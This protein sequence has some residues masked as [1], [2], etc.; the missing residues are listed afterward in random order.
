MRLAMAGIALS[1]IGIAAP[2]SAQD[3]KDGFAL[4]GTTR[5]RYEA[6]DG[7]ARAGFNAADD[8]VNLRTTVLGQY[9]DGPIRIAAELW[10]SRVYAG[11][12][13]TPI[14]TGE[15]NTLE[16]A[17]A[18]AEVRPHAL[19]GAGSTASLQAGRFLLNLGS[20]RLVAA[21][22]YRNTT[23][24]Y[25]G[26][27]AELAWRGGW[28]AILI[29]TLPQQRRPDDPAELR[30]NAVAVD[31]EGVDL[32]LWG[33]TISRARAIRRTM[34]ETSFF[35][36]GE[37]D[38]PQRPTRDRL[39]NTLGLRLISDPAPGKLDGELE[40]FVQHGHI[41]TGL[42]ANAARQDVGA[43][44]VH[45]DAGY[46]WAGDWHPRLSIEFDHASGDRPGGRYGRFDTLLGMRRADLGPSGLYNAFG[47]ANFISPGARI[48]A[49]PSKRTDVMAT[50][51]PIWLAA[52]EDS[53]STT[54]VR[55]AS[56]RSGTFA[57]T[58]V[59][60]RL[61]HRLSPALRLELDAVVLCK[62]RFLRDALNAPPGR[63]T[64]Y[65]SL[66]FTVVL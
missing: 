28:R 11:D 13:G 60:G 50:L 62:G 48:E 58:Q 63:W 41:S 51:R 49:A 25:T 30:H 19:L 65:A 43:W 39:L 54:G 47:R 17:Q 42:S 2:A 34:I 53:F 14:T 31:H 5:L 9:R 44:F 4:S 52:R 18:F 61:R 37:R 1:A 55:D 3:S 38:T 12:K 24:S 59:D 45:A 8:L 7:Q 32:V 40:G 64:K 20:R 35:H 56:G 57:G 6:I 33:G 66:N 10:D 26:L 46:T 27:H 16:L 21:D 23:N 22:D 29:Y 15:V 36:L